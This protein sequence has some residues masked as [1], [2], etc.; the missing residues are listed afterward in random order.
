MGRDWV[1]GLKPAKNIGSKNAEIV[2]RLISEVES[3]PFNNVTA[4]EVEVESYKSK[5]VLEKPDGVSKPKKVSTTVTQYVRDPKVKAWVLKE[6]KGLCECCS[7]PAP[8]ISSSGEPYLEVHHLRKLA[9]SGSDTI[10]NCIALC[11]NCH[12][13]LH[14][15]VDKKALRSRIY[16]S[17][18][19]LV[20]E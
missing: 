9:E 19:R 16:M 17:V 11:P 3:S 8:F 4:F 2:E 7:E 5:K 14:Y 18:G 10:Q 12:R 1:D 6:A 15:S 13:Q 20:A